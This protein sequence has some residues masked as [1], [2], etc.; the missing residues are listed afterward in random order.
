[1][2]YVVNSVWRGKYFLKNSIQS[3]P[4][5]GVTN[6]VVLGVRVAATG[7]TPCTV[8]PDPDPGPP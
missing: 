2:E 1:M 3:S 4:L 5:R 6:L 8:P 7:V